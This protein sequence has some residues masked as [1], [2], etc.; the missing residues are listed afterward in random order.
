M[1]LIPWIITSHPPLVATPN[2]CMEKCVA[3]ASQNLKH[4]TWLVSRYNASPMVMGK[5]P[6]ES[7]VIAKR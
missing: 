2:W 6:L 4:K 3:K 7:L 5:T 1:H